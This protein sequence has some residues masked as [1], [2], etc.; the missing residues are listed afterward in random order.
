M[1]SGCFKFH[2]FKKVGVQA[3]C[4]TSDVR[5]FKMLSLND[6]GDF[7]AELYVFGEK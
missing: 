4:K 3:K 6:A 5:F 7:E 1:K 2:K